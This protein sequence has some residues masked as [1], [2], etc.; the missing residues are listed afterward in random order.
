MGHG[1]RAHELSPERL[2]KS[3]E[4]LFVI[5]GDYQHL[6]LQSAKYAWNECILCMG[7]VVHCNVSDAIF[8]DVVHKCSPLI[9]R[10]AAEAKK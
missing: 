5:D 10:I 8:E 9:R 6:F 4:V 3:L 7:T 2:L 1:H